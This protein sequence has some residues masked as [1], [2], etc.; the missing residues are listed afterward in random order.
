MRT[1]RQVEQQP[2]RVLRLDDAGKLAAGRAL[3][4]HRRGTEG[5]MGD[6]VLWEVLQMRQRVARRG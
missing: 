4:K 6:P 1:A 2:R 5:T 3:R